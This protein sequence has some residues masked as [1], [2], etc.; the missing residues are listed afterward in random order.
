MEQ[1]DIQCGVKERWKVDGK[2]GGEGKIGSQEERPGWRQDGKSMEDE[3]D[4]SSE[5][6]GRWDWE[7]CGRGLGRG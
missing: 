1:L 6:A 2:L 4:D 5:A 7:W 3:D